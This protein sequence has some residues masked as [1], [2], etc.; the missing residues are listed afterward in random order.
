MRYLIIALLIALP[1]TATSVVYGTVYLDYVPY[2]GAKVEMLNIPEENI[3]I[4]GY[5]NSEGEYK[6]KVPYSGQWW[7]HCAI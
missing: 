7:I 4:F 3:Y 5:S 2:E 6:I 1:A